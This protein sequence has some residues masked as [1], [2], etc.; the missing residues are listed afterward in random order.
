LLW[1]QDILS[2]KVLYVLF[3]RS[4]LSCSKKCSRSQRL[5]H[6]VSSESESRGFCNFSDWR[7]GL[8]QLF[9]STRMT[10][11][12]SESL[13]VL[14]SSSFVFVFFGVFLASFVL[15]LVSEYLNPH[16]SSSFVLLL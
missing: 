13:L 3:F 7:E 15:S 16:P 9:Y 14:S 4:F 6:E 10:A 5:L 12:C 1:S 11:E 8:L 2:S